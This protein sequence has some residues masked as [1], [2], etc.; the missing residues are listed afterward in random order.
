M[1]GTEKPIAPSRGSITFGKKRKILE[2][3]KKL[4]GNGNP[5]GNKTKK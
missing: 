4:V 1:Q 3:V 2:T 5:P